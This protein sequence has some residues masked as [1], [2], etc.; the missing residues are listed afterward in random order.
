MSIALN[1]AAPGAISSYTDL[2]DEIRDMMDDDGYDQTK[3]DRAIRKAEAMFLRELRTPEMETSTIFAMTTESTTLPADFLE[4]RAIW[5]VGDP[6]RPLLAVSPITRVNTY[7]GRSG[8][9]VAYSIEGNLIRIAPVGNVS[10]EMIYYR[11]FQ[12]LS[13]VNPNNWLLTLHPDLYVSATL[14][15]L[16]VRER[17]SELEASSLQRTMGLLESIKE[18][19]MKRRWGGA[20]LVPQ[21]IM[22]V[23]G[24]R[25]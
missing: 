3:I 16:A 12:P 11:S 8:D 7:S 25:A 19:E 9:P 23:R 17:D 2:I 24:P 10:L 13:T 4:M 15:Y 21:G 1:L 18:A 6:N 20:S 5:V 14:Y 22:Q